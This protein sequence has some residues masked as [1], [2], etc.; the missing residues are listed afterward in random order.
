MLGHPTDEEFEF[1]LHNVGNLTLTAFNSELSDATF[2][3]KKERA[4]GGF[5]KE[6]LVI[7]NALHGADR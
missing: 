4:I 3:Q 7:L 5:N 1:L 6:H 2:A